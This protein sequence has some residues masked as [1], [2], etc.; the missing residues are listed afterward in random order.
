MQKNQKTLDKRGILCYN[1]FN[2][3]VKC[4]PL[5]DLEYNKPGG[6]DGT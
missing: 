2:K 1:T 4:S 3:T 5:G 6:K